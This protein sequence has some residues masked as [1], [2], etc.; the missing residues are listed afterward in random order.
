MLLNLNIELSVVIA[1]V[2]VAISAAIYGSNET[3]LDIMDNHINA[4]QSVTQKVTVDGVDLKREIEQS[5]MQYLQ[6]MAKYHSYLSYFWHIQMPLVTCVRTIF[7]ATSARP[8]L[9]LQGTVP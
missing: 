8:L 5:D 3:A 6:S 7:L 1:L 4:T 2:F 9:Y